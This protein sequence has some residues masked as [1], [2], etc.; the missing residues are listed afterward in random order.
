MAP[1]RFIDPATQ[2]VLTLDR[3]GGWLVLACAPPPGSGREA[4]EVW[5]D[6]DQTRAMLVYLGEPRPAGRQRLDTVF[7]CRRFAG[8]LFVGVRASGVRLDWVRAADWRTGPPAPG[9]R[10]AVPRARVGQLA[11]A[12]ARLLSAHDPA[13]GP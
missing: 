11:Q 9:T 4:R 5:L 1:L 8:A 2:A 12:I 10:L 3:P 6:V 13:A 7:L